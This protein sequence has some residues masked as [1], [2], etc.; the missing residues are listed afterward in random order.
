LDGKSTQRRRPEYAGSRSIG[1][2]RPK[3]NREKRIAE[4]ADR[5]AA[6][7]LGV[8]SYRRARRYK[9]EGLLGDK[10]VEVSFGLPDAGN[11]RNGDTISSQPPPD[12][13]DLFKKTDQILDTAKGA[14]SN[15]GEA[16]GSLAS[17]GNKVDQGKG[18]I[19]ALVNDKKAYQEVTAGATAFDENMEALK[20]N[21][22]L[23]GFYKK[24]GYE[25]A[26]DLT[27]YEIARCR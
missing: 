8:D 19:G 26:Q 25:D 13:S 27:K 9:S 12:I 3:R 21:F 7:G 16:T 15:I 6:G 5:L 10:Y 18:T 22:L 23:R 1:G 17:I 2:A 14:M 4:T 20:H 24:R 11:V